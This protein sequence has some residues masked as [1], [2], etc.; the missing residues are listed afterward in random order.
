MASAVAT[1]LERALGTHRRRQR[2]Q[3][4]QLAGVDAHQH[5]VRPRQGHQRRRA[6]SAGGHQRR[7]GRC[8]RAPCRACRRTARSIPSQAPIMIL[9]LTSKTQ[10]DQRAL[11]PRVDG[12]GAEGRAGHRRWR[13]RRSAA[14][15]CRRSASSCSRDALT[16]YGISLDDV[17]AADRAAPTCCRPKGTVEDGERALAD[18]GQRPAVARPSSTSR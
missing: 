14:A 2:D 12:A 13:R 3:L 1:P 8:C 6:R 15:R 11:R 9:A 4:E 17:R 18:P 10:H 5:P 7:R 16:Q